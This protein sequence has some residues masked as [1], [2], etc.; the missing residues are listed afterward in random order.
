VNLE[1]QLA[2]LKQLYGNDFPA[3]LAERLNQQWLTLQE[4]LAQLS[5]NSTHLI[6]ED[7][8]HFILGDRPDS[9]VD[10][11]VQVLEQVESD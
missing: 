7:S 2:L 10:A 3:K 11:I 9:V 5:S 4:E 6:V 8:S 1:P